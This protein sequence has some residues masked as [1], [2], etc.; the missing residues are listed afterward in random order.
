MKHEIF[1]DEGRRFFSCSLSVCLVVVKEN[2]LYCSILRYLGQKN[3]GLQLY[4]LGMYF[5][6]W[7]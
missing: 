7:K 3:L 6:A 2:I 5:V 4:K 1:D